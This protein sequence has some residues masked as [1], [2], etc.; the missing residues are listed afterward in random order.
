MKKFFPLL[1]TMAALSHAGAADTDW[2]Q[3]AREFMAEQDFAPIEIKPGTRFE[4]DLARERWA[5]MQRVLLPPF[6]KHLVKWPAQ[7]EAAR[8][9]VQQA[10]MAKIGHPDVDPKRHWE[11]LAKEGAALVKEHVDE[12]LVLWLTAAAVWEFREGQ[13]EARNYLSKAARHKLVKEYPSVLLACIK[14]DDKVIGNIRYRS[15]D[16][17]AKINL[18]RYKALMKSAPDSSVYSPQ[19]DGLLYEDLDSII[20]SIPAKECS[21]ELEQLSATPHFSPW[22]R[23][24]LLGKMQNHI[25]WIYRGEGYANT[26]T[27]DNGSKF[28]EYQIKAR[29]HFLKAWELRP[30]RAAAAASMID[31]VKCGH[32]RPED[33]L[34]RWFDHAITA[35]F[36]NYTAYYNY[37]WALRPRWGGSL[38]KMKA[39]YCA[40]A[41]TE[42]HD[43]AVTKALRRA[44]DYLEEDADD[45]RSLLSQ[46]PMREVMMASLRS[47]ADSQQ[48]YRRWEHPWR[49][50]DMGIMAWKA[51]EYETAYDIFQQVPAPFPRQTRRRMNLLSNETD[52]R[53]QSAIFAFGLSTEWEAAEETYLLGKVDQALQSFQD[54]AARFQGEPPAMLLQRI[55]ACKFEKSFATGK[56]VPLRAFPDMSDWY[57][58]SGFWK[59]LPSG[60]L[61][62]TGH[63]AAAFLIHNGRVGAN[64]ELSG[65]YQ[66]KNAP[67]SQGLCIMLGYHSTPSYEDWVNCAEMGR[68]NSEDSATILRRMF[69]TGTPEVRL[70]ANGQIHRFHIICRDG[71][72]T[73][74]LNHR[75]IVIDYRVTDKSGTAFEMREDSLIGFCSHMFRD[76]SETHIRLMGI[77]KL[78][79]PVAI[80]AESDAGNL[81]SL[82]AGFAK[83]CRRS[84]SD[85][86]AATLLEAE[87]LAGERRR[88]KK[89]AEAD[90][91]MVFA[92]LLKQ[93]AGVKA[94]DMPVPAADETAL[95]T[96]L[97]GYYASQKARLATAQSEWKS[98]ALNL[99]NTA[100]QNEVET[101]I[102]AELEPRPVTEREEPLAAVNAFKWMQVDGEWTRTAEVLTGSGDSTMLYELNRKPPFQIDFDINVLEGNRPRLILRNVKFANESGKTTFGLYPQPRG[103]KLFNYEHNKPYHITLKAMA[104]KT[105]LIID[106]VSI[107]DGPKI[108]LIIDGVSIFDGPKIEGEVGTLQFRGGD[109]SSKGR[110]EFHKIRIS[111]LP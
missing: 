84:V 24:M 9:F 32:G 6:E 57:H 81:E 108:E 110:T 68:S 43:T 44:L 102:H 67:S 80:K 10:L 16:S 23:E 12:P 105:E 77:R 60:T 103:T 56:W 13:T 109:W 21:A 62:N 99:S 37:L 85:L 52:V 61:V 73:Y 28:E 4:S 29:A 58:R 91:I 107:F 27:E 100:E 64:F 98:K 86:N 66:F 47:L 46:P 78:D 35:E 40:C 41:L 38:N 14:A 25:A 30:D 8:S 74:R 83:H 39:L 101:F 51:S 33:T 5:W 31:I 92:G 42:R 45:G 111:P 53:G 15:R 20:G 3:A 2:R 65:L 26:V 70:P 1:W 97:R 18:D 11:A 63:D 69:L 87:Q 94:A 48:V 19:D 93:D 49:L 22:L 104:E 82:R 36:D 54:I 75:D 17:I 106:G 59:G 88:D 76:E 50:A 34:R 96:L 71:A 79:P 7:T 95:A 89:T 55:A 90:K 72:I